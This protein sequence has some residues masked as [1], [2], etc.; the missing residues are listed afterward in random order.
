MLIR[1]FIILKVFIYL[2]QYIK[3]TILIIKLIKYFIIN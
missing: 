1:N 2:I 3:Y